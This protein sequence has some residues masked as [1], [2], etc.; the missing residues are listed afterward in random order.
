[1]K[2]LLS[3]ILTVSF[4]F[5]ALATP[6][7]AAEIESFSSLIDLTDYG[8][9]WENDSNTASFGHTDS[10]TM[11]YSIPTRIV[12]SYVDVLFSYASNDD[13]EVEL[14]NSK[15]EVKAQLTTERV[16]AN[17]FR[18]YGSFSGFYEEAL[19]LHFFTDTTTS[20][21]I[22]IHSFEVGRN[23]YL[24]TDIKAQADITTSY[25]GHVIEYELGGSDN[26][27]F[28]YSNMTTADPT[29]LIKLHADDWRKYDYID[30]MINIF[31]GSINSI[32][33]QFDQEAVPIEVSYLDNSDPS[34]SMYAVC[35]RVDC[36][37]L[38]RSSDGS[39]IVY[40]Y[41]NE[42]PDVENMISVNYVSGY[43]EFEVQTP[44]LYWMWYIYKVI[45]DCADYIIQN[46]S[47]AIENLGFDLSADLTA[48]GDRINGFFGNLYYFLD[49]RF[50]R[51]SEAIINAI[52]G[53]STSAEDF[54]DEL[55]DT[56]GE[57]EGIQDELDNATQPDIESQL[58]NIDTTVTNEASGFMGSLFQIF[59]SNNIFGTVLIF[60]VT[61]ALVSYVFYGKR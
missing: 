58:G 25:L 61:L 28:W 43:V 9:C 17:L 51:M 24:R 16:S 1:M 5:C 46:I 13:V 47:Q 31:S 41:G 11:T 19:I 3:L 48:L 44:F 38:D 4:L 10:L 27:F 23:P 55:D 8:Y 36:S 12:V 20:N 35:I 7:S 39:P 34:F 14:L 30:Y 2:R 57:L 29:Y 45:G 52:K 42:A 21:R 22:S 37:Q 56:L 18:A 33:C 49:D 50:K 60:S 32:S 6:A 54:N 53:D 15:E 40:I 59:I 26:S